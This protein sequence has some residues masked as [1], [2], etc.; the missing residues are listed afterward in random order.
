M[1][2]IQIKVNDIEGRII[3]VG[4]LHTWVLKK[5]K[6][7]DGNIQNKLYMVG[8]KYLE[9]NP[10]EIFLNGDQVDALKLGNLPF[11]LPGEREPAQDLRQMKF[12]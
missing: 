8:N 9:D 2:S 6:N 5:F 4:L 12:V 11:L 3:Q 10:V 1:D 7:E